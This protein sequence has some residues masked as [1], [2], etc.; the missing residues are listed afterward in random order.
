[1]R[2]SKKRDAREFRF[3]PDFISYPPSGTD[4]QFRFFIRRESSEESPKESPKFHLPLATTPEALTSPHQSSAPHQWQTYLR[5]R[6]Y[7][8]TAPGQCTAPVTNAVLR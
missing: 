7:D 1:M 6:N 2:K 3:R 8:V 5:D 4:S